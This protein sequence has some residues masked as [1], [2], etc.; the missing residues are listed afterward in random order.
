MIKAVF[1]ALVF[2][3]AIGGGLRGQS[4]PVPNAQAPEIVSVG[5]GDTIIA[6]T[7]A[8]FSV[9]VTTRAA[10]A[11]QAAAENAKRLE[12]TLRWLRSLGLAPTDLTTVGYSVGQHYEEQRDRRTPAGF[13]ARNTVR[14]EVRKLDDLGRVIDAALS[15]GATEISAPQFLS[16]NTRE[17]RRAALAEALREARADA[18]AIARAAGGALGRLIAANSGVSAPM[19]REAFGE[20]ILT[21]AMAGRMP[22]NIMPRDLTI[23]AQVTARWEF[24]P[25]PAR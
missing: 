4:E 21:S 9:S 10:T 12:S 15:G 3:A 23:A 2:T 14:V 22:T 5:R 11:A 13:V 25:G 17:A 24:V 19:Y 16:T 7:S 1:G 8:A 18:E 20:V 6:P